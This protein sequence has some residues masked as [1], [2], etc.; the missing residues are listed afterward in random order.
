MPVYMYDESALDGACLNLRG[1]FTTYQES[2][3][4]YLAYKHTDGDIAASVAQESDPSLWDP[5]SN[6]Q[7]T[8]RVGK[9][10]DGILD[11]MRKWRLRLV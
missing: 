1:I 2:Q 10:E 4:A 6:T 9:K 3:S 7:G 8:W 11:N 5:G